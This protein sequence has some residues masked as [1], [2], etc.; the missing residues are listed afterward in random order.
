MT[1]VSER[2]EVVRER[3][4]RASMKSGRDPG[5]IALVAVTKTVSAARI[6][7][8]VDAGIRLAGENKVQEAAGKV[9]LVSGDLTWHMVGHLQRNKTKKA[10]EL[11]RMIQSIDSEDLA[12]EVDKRAA[13]AGKRIDVLIEA[14]TSGEPSKFGV[15]PE[16]CI[17]LAEKMSHLSHI[18][19]RGLMTI[20]ALTPDERAVRACFRRL[21]DVRDGIRKANIEH[22]EMTYLSMG[23]TSDFESAIEEGSNMV[24]I[25]TAIF[26]PRQDVLT[27]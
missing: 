10:V 21:R 26:G 12:R 25:G 4:A 9:G 6:Q 20:G 19:V 27:T 2:L 11:F 17:D 24:R 18:S 16:D 8:A 1:E 22:V 15:A 23:M 3:I 14:N 5:E 13:E 7:E